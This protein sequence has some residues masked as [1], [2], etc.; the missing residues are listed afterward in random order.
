MRT[1]TI[2]DDLDP[3]WN[4]TLSFP[5]QIKSTDVI[6]LIVWD[7]DVTSGNDEI[8]QVS[9]GA[10]DM[11]LTLGRPLILATSHPDTYTQHL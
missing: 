8:G 5:V 6:R 1:A 4:Q 7:E 10:L 11:C 9:D 3:M 2:E